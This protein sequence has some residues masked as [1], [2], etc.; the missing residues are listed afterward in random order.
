MLNKTDQFHS[1]SYKYLFHG[2]SICPLHYGYLWVNQLCI[3]DTKV[4]QVNTNCDIRMSYLPCEPVVLTAISWL[5]EGKKKKVIKY[6]LDA[7]QNNFS[8]F[9]RNVQDVIL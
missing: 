6:E 5:L 1:A 8:I 2:L 7:F 3:S 9:F 4:T